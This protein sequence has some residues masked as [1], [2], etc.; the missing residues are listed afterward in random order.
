[1]YLEDHI[2]REHFSGSRET[3]DDCGAELKDR[4]AK[5]LHHIKHQK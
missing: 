2:K 1:M 5:C 3:C 4:Q